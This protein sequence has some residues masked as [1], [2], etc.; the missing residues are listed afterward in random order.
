MPIG[1]L[2]P[3]AELADLRPGVVSTSACFIGRMAS[4]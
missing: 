2:L 1:S 3:T 4:T